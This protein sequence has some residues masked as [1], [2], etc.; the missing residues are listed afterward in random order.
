MLHTA[1][2]FNSRISTYYA[3][4]C[5]RFLEII[6]SPGMR[7]KVYSITPKFTNLAPML[8]EAAKARILQ[9]LREEVSFQKFHGVGFM[10]VHQ[11]VGLNQVFLDRWMNENELHHVVYS[12]PSDR[13]KA[14]TRAGQ[15]H[16]SVCVWDLALQAFEREAWIESVLKSPLSPDFDK[17]L[18]IVCHDDI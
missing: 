15:D 12:S 6:R 9:H 1:T 13:P 14:I 5:V 10:G 11:G 3:P 4:R 2:E 16:N 17:Y 8:L 18:S 7:I